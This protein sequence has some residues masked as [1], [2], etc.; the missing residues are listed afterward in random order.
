MPY[1]VRG[2]LQA[3]NAALVF[4]G[5]GLRQPSESSGSPFPDQCFLMTGDKMPEKRVSFDFA[6][7]FSNGEGAG[8]SH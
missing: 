6:V 3:G 2:Y 1:G 5:L 8:S 7:Q 4:L